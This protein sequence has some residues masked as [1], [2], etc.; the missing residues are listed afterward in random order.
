VSGVGGRERLKNVHRLIRL[1]IAGEKPVLAAVEGYAYGAGLSLAAAC[2][3]V[4]ASREAR[5]G[6]SFNKIGLVPD[7]GAGWT[8]PLRM[9][10]GRAKHI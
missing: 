2:D 5:F 1:L 4:V 8:L 3:I 9:G 6:C 7:L 10:L